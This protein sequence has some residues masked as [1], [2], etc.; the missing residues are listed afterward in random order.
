[1]LTADKRIAKAKPDPRL[2]NENRKFNVYGR[3]IGIILG[4]I[5]LLVRSIFG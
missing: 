1:M 2:S 4:G 3:S 5:Y